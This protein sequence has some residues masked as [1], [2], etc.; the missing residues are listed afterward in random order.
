MN[1]YIIISLLSFV[2]FCSFGQDCTQRLESS[3]RAY[4]S[5]NLKTVISSL[6]DC[7]EN[8]DFLREEVQTALKLLI[9]SH[10]ILKE[11]SLADH[12][13]NQLL[14]INPLSDLKPDELVEYKRL[15]A[16][17]DVKTKQNIGLIIGMNSPLFT[18]L[19]YRS[20]GSIAAETDTYDTKPG[21]V[22]GFKLDHYLTNKVFVSL[23]VLYNRYAYEQKELLLT[24]QQSF[25]EERLDYLNIPIQVG[26]QLAS[27]NFDYFISGGLAANILISS[28]ADL[29]LF[30][31]Q[32]DNGITIVPGIPE[33][34]QAIDLGHQRDG[35]VFNYLIN[36][37]V[38]KRIGLIALE[39][40]AQYDIGINNLVNP[41][42]RF[43]ETEVWERYSYV[44]NDFKVDA[45]KIQFGISRSFYQPLKAK[46]K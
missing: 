36:F 30:G 40:S 6:K 19:Q 43:S 8:G 42:G 14:I 11:D 5:G 37:G 10:L 17:Y 32:S 9:N 25:I 2:A 44:P 3:Q 13:M 33:K 29:E 12:Y 18:T 7:V 38:R 24:Y 31:V 45:F 23:G 4:F 46:N 16:S 21:L 28:K 1:R 39:L 26:Y 22:L 35:I 15:Y 20:L 41:N 27:D 34:A